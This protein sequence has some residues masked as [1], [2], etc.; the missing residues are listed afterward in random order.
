LGLR[1]LAGPIRAVARTAGKPAP[2]GAIRATSRA[3]MS[4]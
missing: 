3:T 1:S 4:R 2:V